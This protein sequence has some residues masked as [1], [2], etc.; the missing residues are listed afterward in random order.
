MLTPICVFTYNRLNETKQM[1]EALQK[2]YLAPESELFIF[3]DG[4]KNE[5]DKLGIN[6]VRQYIQSVRGF[7]SVEIVNSTV[8]K[9]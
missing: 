3:S 1:L 7:Q 4:P 6:E 8:N 2:N 9:V 5:K